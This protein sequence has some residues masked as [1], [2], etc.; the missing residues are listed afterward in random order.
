ML[1]RSGLP[2]GSHD[3]KALMEIIETYPRDE[4]FQIS[5]DELFEIALGIL[6]LG[7]RQRVR[8]FVRRDPYGR[9]VSCLV[10]LPRDR[11]HTENRRRVQEIL[12]E[13]FGG[14]ERRLLDATSRRRSW[15]ASSS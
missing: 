6:H 13:A 7:E 10:Y 4:L 5:E 12:Q 2:P 9:F 14:I 8:L 11:F 1:E 15:R 3:D